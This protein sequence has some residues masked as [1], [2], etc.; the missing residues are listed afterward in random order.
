MDT[1]CFSPM[2][3]LLEMQRMKK[4]SAV[5]LLTCYQD[6]IGRYNPTLNAI[7]TVDAKR[8]RQAADKA[9]RY[10]SDRGTLCGPLHGMPTAVKDIFAVAGMRTTYGNPHFENHVP[11]YHDMVVSRELAAGAVI[12]GK[13]NTPDC[14]SG[15]RTDN[16]IFGLTLNPW[17][18]TRTTSGSGGGGVAALVSGMVAYADGSD[19]GGSVRSPA[20]WTNCV[21]FRPSSGRIPGYANSLADGSTST[22]GVFARCVEDVALFMQGC[23][24]PRGIVPYPT[25]GD[26]PFAD[27]T[28]LPEG[29]R[30]L[31]QPVFSATQVN[32][33]MLSVFES[34]RHCFHASG[35]KTQEAAL[36]FIEMYRQT[37]PGFNA[38][39]QVKALPLEVRADDRAGLPVKRSIRTLIH[40]VDALSVPDMITLFRQRDELKQRVRDLFARYDA[41]VCP[42]HCDLAFMADDVE[43]AHQFDWADLFFAPLLGLPSVSVPMGW[44][45][46]GMPCGLMITGPAGSD[47]TVLQIAHA[48]QSNTQY[49]RQQPDLSWIA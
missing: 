15:G 46:D 43:S 26:A 21:G 44:T 13:T 20:A 3:E 41:I 12:M 23:D 7:V 40:A 35:I 47:K 10:L 33:E 39:V 36:D 42:T 6:H 14:A 49:Y 31:W 24:G 48:F 9:D 5:E 30:V 2:F 29:L 4:I 18:R 22:A 17:N 27:V 1:I 45:A 16:A 28:C 19:V 8:A 25:Q 37:Y 34:H 32:E 11:N 38:F